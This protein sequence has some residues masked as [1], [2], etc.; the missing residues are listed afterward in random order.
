MGQQAVQQEHG[1]GKAYVF[2]DFGYGCLDLLL[3]AH[4][5]LVV[6]HALVLGLVVVDLGR[7]Q[8]GHVCAP[9]PVCLG[10]QA[11]QASHA[12]GNDNDLVV[13]T[14]LSRAAVGDPVAEDVED[15]DDAH[16]HGPGNGN[17]HLKGVPWGVLSAQAKDDDAGYPRVEEGVAQDVP[18]EVDGNVAVP[19]LIGAVEG[20]REGDGHLPELLMAHGGRAA[21]GGGSE[22]GRGMRDAGW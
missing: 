20:A 22:H 19:W 12:A 4:V 11:A 15:A 18:D 17:A 13:Q 7:V 14:D 9:H 10:Q 21:C 1:K 2:H 16:E 8:D 6:Q 5:A 3:V